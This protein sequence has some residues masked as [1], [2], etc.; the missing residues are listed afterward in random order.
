MVG[1]TG[2]GQAEVPFQGQN[3]GWEYH[4]DSTSAA[5]TELTTPEQVAHGIGT[6]SRE[7]GMLSKGVTRP[8]IYIYVFL[9]TL[10]KKENLAPSMWVASLKKEINNEM[11]SGK[12]IHGF[13]LLP[14]P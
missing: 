14:S 2:G 4:R 6:Q 7:Y 12:Q 13:S 1:R 8:Y 10:K 3:G 5:P 9:L 11:S